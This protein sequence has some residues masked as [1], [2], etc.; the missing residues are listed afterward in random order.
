MSG[1]INP[2]LRGVSETLLLP[3]YVRAKESRRPDA[4]IHDEDAARI[5]ERIDFDFS[6][7]KLRA[8][9]EVAVLMR[10]REFDCQVRS[11]LTL[12]HDSVVVH[13]GCGLDTR[14]ARVDN[15]EVEWYDLDLPP[16]IDLRRELMEE[17]C[18]RHHLLATSVFEEGWLHEVSLHKPRPFLFLAEG[19]FPYFEEAQVKSLVVRLRDRFPGAELAF[20]GMTPFLIWGDNLH[21]AL[22]GLGARLHWGLK[23]AGDLEEWGAGICLLKEWYYFDTPESRLGGFQWIFRMLG[24]STGIFQYRLG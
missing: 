19:V 2:K 12:H 3:L 8:H 9:D 13:I 18:K 6:K 10:A 5:M 7:L 11:F 1:K 15:G 17:Q 14:F 23:R 21:L 22:T 24:K 4:M 20:D 16:V